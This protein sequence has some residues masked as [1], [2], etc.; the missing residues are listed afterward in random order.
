MPEEFIAEL[1]E[2]FTRCDTDGDFMITTE[3]L[4]EGLGFYFGTNGVNLTGR[5][6]QDMVNMM[7][8]RGN[9]PIDFPQFLTFVSKC[10]PGLP[11]ACSGPSACSPFAL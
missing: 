4:K 8:I 9:G 5:Q 1:K 11:S 7:G 2:V 10:V 3:E 6:L